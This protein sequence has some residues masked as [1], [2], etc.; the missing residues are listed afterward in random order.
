MGDD[1]DRAVDLISH[2]FKYLD[3]AVKAPEINTCF[4]LVKNRKLGSSC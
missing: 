1:Q 4:R 3:Q 2:F